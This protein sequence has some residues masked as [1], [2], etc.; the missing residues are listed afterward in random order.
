MCHGFAEGGRIITPPLCSCVAND[1]PIILPLRTSRV[2]PK[3]TDHWCCRSSR[4]GTMASQPGGCI[5]PTPMG[6]RRRTPGRGRVRRL[7]RAR[8]VLSHSLLQLCRGE[9]DFLLAR[10]LHGACTFPRHSHRCASPQAPGCMW[11]DAAAPSRGRGRAACSNWHAWSRPRAALHRQAHDACQLDAVQPL[12]CDASTQRLVPSIPAGALAVD[13]LND[14]TSGA[15]SHGPGLRSSQQSASM[16]RGQHRRPPGLGLP[17]AA[18]ARGVGSTRDWRPAQRRHRGLGPR[19]EVTRL[20]TAA[21]VRWSQRS[22][23]K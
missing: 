8:R 11:A 1:L 21:S 5:S 10:R 4:R 3:A 15:D 14:P 23:T 16:V 7:L 13:R 9:H 12:G 6:C 18:P 19:S 2:Q 22:L 20:N 17:W